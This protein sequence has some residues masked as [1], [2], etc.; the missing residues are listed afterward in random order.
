MSTDFPL[1][2]F[3]IHPRFLWFVC[4]NVSVTMIKG[5][6]ERE[7]QPETRQRERENNHCFVHRRR[8]ESLMGRRDR[9]ENK[10]GR[11]CASVDGR[12]NEETCR[13][14][15]SSTPFPGADHWEIR[16]SQADY[17][18]AWGLIR[19]LKDYSVYRFCAVWKSPRC[20]CLCVWVREGEPCVFVWTM[21]LCAQSHMLTKG[22]P[23]QC[24]AYHVLRKGGAVREAAWVKRA[25]A[26]E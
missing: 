21:K 2:N 22:T 5:Q 13:P 11:Y 20:L 25:T 3:F 7:R 12:G 23:P 16:A 10:P 17:L 26:N 8:P 9:S 15:S 19:L 14:L 24:H 1:C 6:I 4:V 18:P